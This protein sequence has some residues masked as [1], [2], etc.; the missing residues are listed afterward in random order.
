L[1]FAENPGVARSYREQLSGTVTT[2]DKAVSNKVQ[3]Y[4]GDFEPDV[5]DDNFIRELRSAAVADSQSAKQILRA[6]E[7]KGVDSDVG[8]R[9][10]YKP[11]DYWI[12]DKKTGRG[13]TGPYESRVKQ[14]SRAW[15]NT[16]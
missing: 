11:S 13:L 7:I 5:V 3:G 15:I 4:L 12:A 6:S 16:I 14:H 10:R 9:A 2:T 8:I 1:Y